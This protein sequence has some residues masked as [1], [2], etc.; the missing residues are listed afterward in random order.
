M[1]EPATCDHRCGQTEGPRTARPHACDHI[2]ECGTVQAAQVF[3]AAQ[4]VSISPRPSRAKRYKWIDE[5]HAGA[6][7]C[8]PRGEPEPDRPTRS[9][10]PH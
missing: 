4:G 1:R 3:L 10:P 5:N 2:G 8:K 6:A 9:R 7:P